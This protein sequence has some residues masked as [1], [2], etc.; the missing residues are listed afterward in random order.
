M[1]N[2][3]KIAKNTGFLLIS[4][5]L[6]YILA[7]LYLLY[8]ARFL[9]PDNYGLLS[10]GLAF[11]GILGILADLGLNV[12]IVREIARNKSLTKKYLGNVILIKIILAAIT[13]GLTAFILNLLGYN[14]NTIEIVYIFVLYMIITT[15][16]QMFY[17]I[18]QAHQKM[19]YQSIGESLSSFLIF[20]GVLAGIS[21]GFNVLGFSFIY[22]ISSIIILVY[23]LLIY[24]KKFFIPVLEIDRIF[25]KNIIYEAFPLGL[26]SIFTT[27]Y[28]WINSVLLSLIQGNMA[29]GFYNAAYNLIVALMFIPGV[30]IISIFPVMSDHFTSAKNLLIKE[31][32][33]SF[34]Y[35]FIIAILLFVYGSLFA[36]KI[37]LMIYGT[38]FANSIEIFRILMC[39][40]PIIFI[41]CL[42]G[43]LLN[44]INKQRIVTIVAGSN[45]LLNISLNLLL[46]SK[47]SYIGASVATVFTELLGFIMMFI[48]ISKYFSKISIRRNIIK[49]LIT[50][51]ILT[52]MVYSLSIYI[53]WILSCVI[54]L[55]L[56]LIMLYLFKVISDEDL[57]LV[58]GIFQ[59]NSKN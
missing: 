45:L 13:I 59:R 51:G 44:A 30:F 37:I 29:V 48:Y 28:F 50:G 20:M 7:F 38:N 24:I 34:L 19:E 40:I 33:K 26:S 43:T 12:L 31:Y 39:V 21:F 9:G 27:L 47:F 5:I 4:R 10:L 25:W 18:F 11:A 14:H 42:F 16:S 3:R 8:L 32:E 23:N 1:N 36:D 17:A 41:T 6:S 35:L 15:F 22:L 52:I 58:R 46:I 56:Y 2:V 53:N 57:E 55:I 54:G 49:P